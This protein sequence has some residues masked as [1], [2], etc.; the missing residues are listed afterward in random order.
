MSFDNALK[1]YTINKGIKL[2]LVEDD[3]NADDITAGR[4]RLQK[5]EKLDKLSVE[6]DINA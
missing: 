3:S 5:I 6:F 4:H 2:Q 1:V